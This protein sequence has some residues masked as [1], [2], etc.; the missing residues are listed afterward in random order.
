MKGSDMGFGMWFLP[1]LFVII[2]FYVLNE[3]KKGRKEKTSAQDL[4]DKRY[5]KGDIDLEEYE[6]KSRHLSEHA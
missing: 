6:E 4:L 2:I 3:N 1:I 5:A